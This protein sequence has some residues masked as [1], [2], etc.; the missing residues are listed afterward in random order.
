MAKSL[1]DIINELIDENVSEKK[2]NELLDEYVKKQAAARTKGIQ[3]KGGVFNPEF[4]GPVSM[5]EMV[6][7]TPEEMDIARK[8]AKALEE[9]QTVN[10]PEAIKQVSKKTKTP[11]EKI[12]RI[13][14]KSAVES[15][16]P[17]KV[18]EF[19]K[20]K[21]LEQTF[22]P[23]LEKEAIRENLRQ[24]YASK[25]GSAA[26]K[27]EPVVEA[28]SDAEKYAS[29]KPVVSPLEE[30]IDA[31]K[32]LPTDIK[33]KVL[34]SLLK[35]KTS[36]IDLLTKGA[37]IA[38]PIQ[39]A[40]AGAEASKAGGELFGY[41][42]LTTK[43][44]MGKTAKLLGGSAMA[45][46]L[47]ME[48][49]SAG[50]ATPVAIPTGL[51]GAG[52]YGLGEYLDDSGQP[53]VSPAP[54]VE[55]DKKEA[56]KARTIDV[57]DKVSEKDL[58]QILEK[59]RPPVEEVKQ[60][61]IE[62]A[63][64]RGEDPA[65]A[66]AQMA[67]ESS[68][69]P[70][71]VSEE[72]AMGLGQ[73]FPT[74]FDD[75]KKIDTKGTLKNLSY[76]EAMQPENW[77]AQV[78]AFFDY[79]NWLKQ[80]RNPQNEEEFL[81][82]YHAGSKGKY[83]NTPK[84][85]E[86]FNKILRRKPRYEKEL[87][88]MN[89][90]TEEE[91]ELDR[92]PSSVA[93]SPEE[94]ADALRR[95][96]AFLTSSS[97]NLGEENAPLSFGPVASGEEYNKF[98]QDQE[99]LM[100]LKDKYEYL[101]GLKQTPFERP[102]P[103]FPTAEVPSDTITPSTELEGLERMA[104]TQ[105]DFQDQLKQAQEQRKRDILIGQVGKSVMPIISGL[106]GI[107]SRSKVEVPEVSAFDEMIKQAGMPIAELKE[108]IAIEK[109]DPNSDASKMLRQ[110][111][112]EDVFKATGKRVN[113]G[114]MSYNQLTEIYPNIS[115]MAERL[116]LAKIKKEERASE[117]KKETGEKQE[118]FIQALRKETTSGALGKMFSNY[119]TAKR[120]NAAIEEFSKDPTGYSDYATLMGGL[121][122][123]QG[124]DSVVRE[125]EVRL[126]MSATSLGNKIQNWASKLISGK[127]LQ[128]EQRDQM[129]KAVK[130][131]SETARKQYSDAI[132]PV[133]KQAESIGIDKKMLV[134]E[135]FLDE[136]KNPKIQEYADKY[137]GG[138]YNEAFKILESRRKK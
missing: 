3:T 98:R 135:G 5:A 54:V 67:Q 10:E 60:Y 27:A 126:G 81:K 83:Y 65:L 75:A 78:D 84:N 74:A 87:T 108:K 103:K 13:V 76:E 104:Q 12:R 130:I 127:S 48:I 79:R 1:E 64:E 11:A 51:V 52:L 111:A 100:A 93:A 131:L 82:F 45:S 8:S 42:N 119:N 9:Y 71:E 121:K 29:I 95:L 77:K 120:M 106:Y 25:L 55:E 41:D 34:S 89:Q 24:R 69:N 40:I 43:Q 133:M 32:K 21:E 57:L 92:S 50:A 114:N 44:K 91:Q 28:V 73:H 132:S 68:F 101:K 112:E 72:G 105:T 49:I 39:T 38:A 80:N 56:D 110:L 63:R 30:N 46:V 115:R 113:F 90:L 86:Y 16:T 138:N 116:E 37:K 18:D 61:V 117:S 17:L 62:Q 4:G 31:L 99:K 20:Q 70:F 58:P 96:K 23:V 125:A 102:E 123:L 59:N 134:G 66:L 35:G 22:K 109:D 128:P 129:I 7:V 118:K 2:S 33:N 14:T 47:P 19:V 124:D 85:V 136:E 53:V 107:G 97:T 36:A 15:G 26:Q 88:G 122:A 137:L 6:D 94:K